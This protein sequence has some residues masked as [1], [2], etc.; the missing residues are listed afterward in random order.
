MEQSRYKLV[1]FSLFLLVLV[2]Y[3][4]VTL[5]VYFLSVAWASSVN[6]FM[7][8]LSKQKMLLIIFV[9]SIGFGL[10]NFSFFL[11]YHQWQISEYGHGFFFFYSF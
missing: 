4:P 9:L 10:I 6:S 8:C 1:A 2:G 5:V 7:Y 11:L 3:T